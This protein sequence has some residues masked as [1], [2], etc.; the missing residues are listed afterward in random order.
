MQTSQDEI[1]RIYRID[2]FPVPKVQK[3]DQGF[4]EGEVVASRTGIFNYYDA[5]GK[6]RKELRHPDDVLKEDSLKT[7]KMIPVTDDHPQEFVDVNNASALQKGFTGE[8]Y[9]TDEDGN[10]VVRIKVTDSGLINK[11]LSGRKTELSLGYSV[12]LKKDEGTYKGERYDYRQTDIVYNHLAV[13][14]MGRAGR[15]ARFRLDSKKTCEL[16]ETR[17]NNDNFKSIEGINMS[18]TEK[19][20][21]HEVE[22]Q[23]AR[24]DALTN[25]RDL[26][27]HKLD[28][29]EAKSKALE[30]TLANVTKERDDLKQVNLDSIINER[31]IERTNIAVRA[32]AVLGEDFSAYTHHSNREIMEAALKRVDSK[33]GI[34]VS[35]NGAS[36]E[37][38]KGVFDKVTGAIATKRNDTNKAYNL[39]AAAHGA[40]D[41]TNTAHD[42][43]MAKLNEKK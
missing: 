40:A 18:D 16:A 4:L 17:Y 11:I 36:D 8:S 37:Y 42:I 12:A 3:T 34:E 22:V 19:K 30:S 41:R 26:L 24:F 35:Y 15:N 5:D 13:V 14:E 31:A 29:A 25:E 1:I 39:V 6:C 23:K 7:L 9:R 2:T 20:L 38:V 33:N 28:T 10:I 43:I 32:A 21:D 27:K